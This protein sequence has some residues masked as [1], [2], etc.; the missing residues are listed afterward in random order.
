MWVDLNSRFG[1]FVCGFVFDLP[2]FLLSEDTDPFTV[3]KVLAS[4]RTLQVINTEQRT[5]VRKR[6]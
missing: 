1:W 3:N 4:Q 5:K 2:C 6:N